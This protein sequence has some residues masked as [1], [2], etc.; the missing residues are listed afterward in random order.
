MPAPVQQDAT[1]M[2]S[3]EMAIDRAEALLDGLLEAYVAHHRARLE[4]EAATP[5]P[6]DVG[7]KR[8]VDAMAQ[9]RATIDRL[10]AL[11]DENCLKN[12]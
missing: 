6:Y 4:Q 9:T 7:R 3:I 5:R 12:Q 1:E 10:R 2:S 11:T 8:I